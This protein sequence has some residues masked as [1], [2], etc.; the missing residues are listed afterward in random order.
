MKTLRVLT[1]LHA[2]ASLDLAA[3]RHRV[4]AQE[5]PADEIPAA[6]TS[7][8][9]LFDWT[10]SPLLLDIGADGTVTPVPPAQADAQETLSPA[11]PD[12]QP[13]R[14]GNVVLCI[15]ASDA[16]WVSDA[17]LLAEL[18][19]PAAQPMRKSVPG[20]SAWGARVGVLGAGLL[21]A[22]G[23]LY[24]RAGSAAPEPPAPRPD[25]CVERLSRALA[26][27]GLLELQVRR[28][29]HE[30][31]LSGLVRDNAQGRAVRI[32]VT[33]AESSTGVSVAQTWEVADDIAAT[34][35]TALRSPGVHGRY[36]GAGR[37]Q[38]EGRSAD[39]QRV[40]QAVGQLQNDLGPNVK[41]ID[42]SIERIQVANPFS[43]AIAV[44]DLRYSERPDG[45]KVFARQAVN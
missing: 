36:L 24:G 14:F 37:F 20:P 15:G 16:R 31:L 32:A 7:D 26:H 11:W 45:A 21:V 39:P 8:I 25:H 42:L 44:G 17:D 23:A 1:G 29:K 40:G 38:V 28:G 19:E 10:A 12:M 3:G 22:V 4:G 35:E 5:G 2:G 41:A 13:R 27:E 34:I 18:D 9:V 6:G 43:V 33:D 30:V